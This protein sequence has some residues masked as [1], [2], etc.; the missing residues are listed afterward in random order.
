MKLEITLMSKCFLIRLRLFLIKRRRLVRTLSGLSIWRRRTEKKMRITTCYMRLRIRR[1]VTHNMR[2]RI[3]RSSK[4]MLL[5]NKLAMVAHNLRLRIRR[6]VDNH[7]RLRIWRRRTEKNL[8]LRMKGV[9]NLMHRFR[10]KIKIKM[11]STSKA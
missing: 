8:K 6:I 1:M 9:N 3:T 11:R 2:V 4:M 7:M 10:L 5:M